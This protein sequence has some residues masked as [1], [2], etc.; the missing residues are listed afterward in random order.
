MLE[1]MKRVE[2]PTNYWL[3]LLPSY[4]QNPFGTQGSHKKQDAQYNCKA[5]G[6]VIAT[7]IHFT[8][9]K[10]HVIELISLNAIEMYSTSHNST[11]TSIATV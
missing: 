4:E 5:P 10:L 11:P 6:S 3:L 9:T 2:E 8:Q 7:H 1:P